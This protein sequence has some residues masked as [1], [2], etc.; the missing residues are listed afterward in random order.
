MDLIKGCHNY[1][2]QNSESGTLMEKCKDYTE[3]Q[4]YIIMT[5][6]FGIIG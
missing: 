3:R 6:K 5:K 1:P 2:S 4:F